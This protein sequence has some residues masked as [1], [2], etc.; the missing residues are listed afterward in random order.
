MD[1][2]TATAPRARIAIVSPDGEVANE[3]TLSLERAGYQITEPKDG[4]ADIGLVDLRNKR[5]TAKQAKS[6]AA[7]LRHKSPESSIFFLIHPTLNTPARTALKRYGETIPA[8]NNFDHVVERCRQILRLRNVADEAGERMK[9]LATLNRLFEFPSIATSAKPINVLIAGP[10]SPTALATISAT[11]KTAGKYVSVLSAG[12]ALRAIDT[13][14]FDCAIFLPSPKDSPL[15]SVTRAIRRHPKYAGLPI[16][17]V[18]EDE[19]NL[20]QLAKYGASEFILQQHVPHD[21]SA[22]IQLNGRRARLLRSMRTFLRACTGDGVRDKASHAFTPAFL[23]EHGARLSARADHSGRPLTVVFIQLTCDNEDTTIH[24]RMVL[25]R[26]AYLIN[27]ITRAE[28][29][30]A[31]I[32]PDAFIVLCPATTKADAGKLALRIEGVI[33]NT[34]FR[35]RD[36]HS[37]HAIE[38]V[39]TICTRI[40]GAA[41]EE[42]VACA[43]KAA[44][45]IRGTT[46]LQQSP[47]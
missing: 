5:V 4:P 20:Q 17:H 6:I 30:T 9:T 42:A 15:H 11:A 47:R 1:N 12:Q 21:L 37:L 40:P 44:R 46:P 22:R 26:A 29:L 35:G 16:I 14:Q 41:I 45:C 33:A 2:N 38:A 25:H 32:A 31:R 13:G 10:P 3:L 8:R 19:Q 36:R 24:E 23:A 7:L 43:I 18:A 34:V 27:R 39:T 28:D